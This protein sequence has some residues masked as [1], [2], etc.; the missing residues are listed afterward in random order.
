M[1]CFPINRRAFLKLVLGAATSLCASQAQAASQQQGK[2]WIQVLLRQQ[3][4]IA[5]EGNRMVRSIAVSTGKPRTPTP[6][7]RFRIYRKYLRVRMRGPDYDLPNVP[8][9]MFFRA[10]G[11]AI[12]GTYWHNNF[13]RP[14]SHGCVNLP[15]GE[16]AW[17]YQWAPLGTPVIIQ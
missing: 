4:L 14:M 3:R 17:L 8:Y 15:V 2:K 13:G 7:G 5:W 12:H 6:R 10:G 16:A 11:Y 9:V 1:D